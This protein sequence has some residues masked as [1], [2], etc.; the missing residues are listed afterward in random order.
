ML[1]DA[2]SI[3]DG[4]EVESDVCVVGAG[5]AGITIAR[6]LDRGGLR[7][8]VLES[9]GLKREEATQKL[10]EG[11]SVGG[12]Y[13]VGGLDPSRA[14]DFTRLRWFGGTTNHWGGWCRPLDAIDFEQRP[15]VPDSGWPIT[16]AELEPHYVRAHDVCRLGPPEYNAAV[17]ARR[18]RRKPFP[19]GGPIANE[20]YQVSAQPRFAEAYGDDLR[21][22]RGVRVVLH[23]NA[24]GLAAARDASRIERVRVATLS[25]R[26]FDV[27][28][29][30]VVLAAGGV[31][32]ARLMLVSNDVRPRGIGNDRDL[33]GR[34]FSDHPHGVV[35]LIAYPERLDLGFF[36]YRR[37]RGTGLLG[38]LATTEEFARAEGLLRF[39]ATFQAREGRSELEPGVLELLR[40]T[41]RGDPR[42]SFGAVYSRSEMAPNRDNRVTLADTKD[43]LGLPRIRVAWR[44]G[45]LE[46]RSII[47]SSEALGA[48][49]GRAGARLFSFPGRDESAWEQELRGGSHHVGTTR[50]HDDPRRGVVDAD[51][52]VHGVQNLFVAGSSV[53]PTTGWS[54]PTLTIVALAL[55][56]AP[57]VV[58]GMA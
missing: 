56:L 15:G 39:S 28:A 2:R 21:R 22:S 3:D 50:M 36:N 53:F 38:A 41:G 31:E 29:R 34:Y 45:E 12:R 43:A 44:V 4:A 24:V 40:L 20:V 19:V 7:V 54:N 5:A 17:W 10:Y 11:E 55:R 58:K 42:G 52:R 35:A 27:R 30:S 47:A 9:G 16:R 8:C 13:R 1:I 26:R 48:V 23:A 37:I 6:E 51:C 57:T 18:A 32:N 46:R 33:V 14:L 25:G 49:L